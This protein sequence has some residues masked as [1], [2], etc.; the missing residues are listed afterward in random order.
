MTQCYAN[1]VTLPFLQKC[2]FSNAELLVELCVVKLKSD[3]MPLLEL[4]AMVFNPLCKF[5]I[6]NGNRP[7]ET[8]PADGPPLEPHELSAR[9][10]EQ[11]PKVRECCCIMYV[12]CV[13]LH[14]EIV[15]VP[16]IYRQCKSMVCSL[17]AV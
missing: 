10:A 8:A 5:H 13:L 11:R 15:H 17:R 12:R 9:C 2:I 7:S 3:W 6:Y 4:L 14:N 1:A 16:M